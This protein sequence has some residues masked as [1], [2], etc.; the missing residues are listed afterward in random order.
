LSAE[1]QLW[2][3]VG[4]NGAGKSTFYRLYLQ[5]LGLPFVNADLLAQI[6]YPEA[7]EQSSYEAALLAQEQRQ[8]LLLQGVSFCFET[9][10]SH[11]SKIDFVGRAKA[12]GY[13]VVMV[14][15]HLSDPSLNQARI[16]MRVSQGGHS[17]PPDKVQKRIPR[18]LEQVKKSL[19]LC[20]VLRAYDNSS[21][22][23]PF[24]PVF[25]ISNGSLETHLAPLP[26]WAVNLLAD[27]SPDR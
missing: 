27:S 15:I 9:V 3:L 21:A 14:F 25:T 20:D 16:S 6:A 7:P 18:L 19:P 1:K 12:L 24:M 4:G 5:P 17:V 22:D 8:Q 11:P 23:H 26:S 2:V 10:Y 13:Q